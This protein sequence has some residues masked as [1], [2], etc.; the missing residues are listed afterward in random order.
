MTSNGSKFQSLLRALNEI[1]AEGSKK[2]RKETSQALISQI[3]RNSRELLRS[4][5]KEEQ[6]ARCA[7]SSLHES[8]LEKREGALKEV[9]GSKGAEKTLVAE[10]INNAGKDVKPALDSLKWWRLPIIVDDITQVVSSAAEKA[11]TNQFKNK[12]RIRFIFSRVVR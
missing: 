8:Y 2:L 9:L 4:S 1:I 11:Y 10:A 3:L 12:V 5:Q 6:E 7:V